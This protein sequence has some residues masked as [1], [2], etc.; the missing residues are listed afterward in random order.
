[1]R[2]FAGLSPRRRGPGR[3]LEVFAGLLEWA[4]VAQRVRSSDP[5]VKVRLR[6]GAGGGWNKAHIGGAAI[7]LLFRMEAHQ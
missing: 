2:T 3:R 5:R 6:N 4:G 1:M 7:A